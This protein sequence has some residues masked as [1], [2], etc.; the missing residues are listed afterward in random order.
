MPSKGQWAMPDIKRSFTFADA[1]VFAACELTALPMCDAGWHAIVSGEQTARGIIAVI[2]GA[3]I[4]LCGVS[5]HWWKDKISTSNKEWI[6]RQ[7]SRWWPAVFV[8]AFLYFTAPI[9]Y[10]RAT[11]PHLPPHSTE[12]IV[13][14]FDQTARG[15]GYFLYMTKTNDQ[16]IRVLGL[17]AHGKNSSDKPIEHF[18]GFM[19]SGLTNV[20]K[21]IY[22][23]GEDEAEAKIPA[24]T[25][26]VPTLPVQT[27]GIPPF[28][29]FDVTTIEKT[30]ITPGQDGIPATQFVDTFAPFT[31]ALEYDGERFERTFTREEIQNQISIFEKS[32][33]RQ[34]VPRILRKP[35]ADRPI[36]APLQPYIKM[37]P[38][39]VIPK[40]QSILPTSKE[41]TGTVP[42]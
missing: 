27:F 3:I 28:A 32:L 40:L 17:Q 24:C 11:V 15:L 33:S 38:V 29:D 1:G 25:P 18:G 34:N 37:T 39:P 10:Q 41:E 36:F 35:D 6:Q 42:H 4:G 19:R 14:T 7:A 26:R 16:E 13:W 20:Q 2:V 8:L 22:I 9:A 21:T 5:F 12:R 23:L 30:I 31:V